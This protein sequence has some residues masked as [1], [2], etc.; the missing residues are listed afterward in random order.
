LCDLLLLLLI[1]FSLFNLACLIHLAPV[2]EEEPAFD[3]KVWAKKLFK[4]ALDKA[5]SP[6]IRAEIQESM[7]ECLDE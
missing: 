2:F 7:E 3:D 5:K 4:I 6:K 1:K